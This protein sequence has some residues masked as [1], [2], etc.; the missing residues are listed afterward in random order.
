MKRKRILGKLLLHYGISVVLILMMAGIAYLLQVIEI[1][2]RIPTDVIYCAQTDSYMAYVGKNPF[3]GYAIGDLITI[4]ISDKEQLRFDVR[5][6]REES[7][8]MVL[9]LAPVA[10]DAVMR[11]H[12]AGDTKLSG[13]VFTNKVKL[14]NLIFSKGAMFDRK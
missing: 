2:N 3:R 6:V 7:T 12:F 14:W 11:R 10:P 9:Q 8:L 1:R 4:D 5:N 13:F